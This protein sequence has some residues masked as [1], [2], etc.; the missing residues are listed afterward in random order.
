MWGAL[1]LYYTDGTP[2]HYSR[3]TNTAADWSRWDIQTHQ[4]F[5]D[6]RHDLGGG[7]T[8]KASVMH[9]LT[10]GDSDLFYVYGT[11]DKATGDGLY[12]YPSAYHNHDRQWTAEA[13]VS[14]PVQAF[15]R[16][17]DLVL[18]GNWGRSNSFQHSDYGQG[19]GTPLPGM[20]AFDGSYPE[21]SFDA[22]IGEA[23]YYYTRETGY[24][25]A[26]LS[27]LDPLKLIVGTNV[28]HVKMSGDSYGAPNSYDLTRALP[29]AGLVYEITPDISAYASYAQIFNPQT[30]LDVNN[31]ILAPIEGDNVEVGAKGAW[32][33]EKLNASF[34]LFQARQN[35]TA[36]SAGYNL[37]TGQYYYTGINATSQGIEAEIS[38]QVLPQVQLSAG[39]TVMKIEG[40]DGRAVRT[41]VPRQTLRLAANYQPTDKLKLGA[42]LS[43]QSRMYR[44]QDAVS[45]TTGQ[46]IYTTQ[47]A[48]ALLGVMAHYDIDRNWS[49]TANLNNLTDEKYLTSL[50]WSQGY[51]GAGLN[52]TV[53]INWKM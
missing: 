5:A 6:I 21:P 37:A 13:Y 33:N 48:F 29:Y 45:T 42:T 50:Y 3:G 41:Y 12:S 7:W 16:T 14:G 35:N 28:T 9:S 15:D 38:G 34:A 31:Q 20:S 24:L 11:P 23:H 46:E 4:M 36:E 40:D 1:P 22:Y 26:R 2:T 52:G 30:Q 18:G 53:T 32:F 43:W 51:Y 47:P 25:A 8:A 19:I 39:Y 17:H 44:D 49:V 27:L 10:E